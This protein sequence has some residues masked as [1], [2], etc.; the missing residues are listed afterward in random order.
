M[1]VK[2]AFESSDGSAQAPAIAPASAQAATIRAQL[3]LMF[4]A[5]LADKTSQ[6][7]SSAEGAANL[8]VDV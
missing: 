6:S 2:G 4:G 7:R 5:R 8:T 3:A 1:T